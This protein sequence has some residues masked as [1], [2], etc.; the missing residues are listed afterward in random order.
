M[1]GLAS[2]YLEI[3]FGKYGNIKKCTKKNVEIQTKR[4]SIRTALICCSV[5]LLVLI[6]GA[7]ANQCCRLLLSWDTGGGTALYSAFAGFVCLLLLLKTEFRGCCVCVHSLYIQI[8]ECLRQ[9]LVT[10]TR[11]SGKV[12]YTNLT[13]LPD[14]S[15]SLVRPL[16]YS[17]WVPVH[18]ELRHRR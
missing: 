7:V 9:G 14:T 12:R 10:G 1:E 3:I 17:P 4:P 8:T 15:V 11:P 5:L 16:Q 6:A 2:Q 13:P 18:H